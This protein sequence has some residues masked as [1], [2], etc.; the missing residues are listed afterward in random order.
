[1]TVAMTRPAD[2]RTLISPELFGRLTDRIAIDHPE[3]AGRADQIME[4]AIAFLAACA[5]RPGLGLAPSEAVDIGWHTFILYTRE[6]AAFCERVA[7]R[8]IHHAPNDIP[9]MPGEGSTVSATVRVM[10]E[11]GLPVVEDLWAAH[12]GDCS[13][14]KCNSG[15]CNQCHAGC[16][17]SPKPR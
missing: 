6:Y 3:H 5:A 7:G 10:G 4:Q 16:V 1:M 13:N 9:G 15:K 11:L 14:D 17:D 2:V 12:R 8:F